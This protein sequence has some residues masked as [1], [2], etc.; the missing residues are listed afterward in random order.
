MRTDQQELLI[1]SIRA[2]TVYYKKLKIVPATI[3]Q[4]L[5][6][7]KIYTNIYD[8]CL[9]SGIMTEENLEMW[10]ISNNLLPKNFAQKKKDF[11]NAIDNT[12]ISLYKNRSSK[13]SIGKI[14]Y[15]LQEL[16]SDLIR[17]VEP[18][19]QYSQNTCEFI[20]NLEKRM[21]LLKETTFYNKKLYKGSN[22]NRVFEAWQDSLISEKNIRLLARSD[23][24][25]QLWNTKKTNTVSLFNY[26]DKNVELTINQRNL[27]TWSMIYDNVYESIESPEESVISDDDMLDG[28]F[29]SQ[30]EKREKEQTQNSIE[31]KIK[32][33]KVSN[34]GHV[35]VV[36]DSEEERQQINMASSH[37]LPEQFIHSQHGVVVNNEQLQT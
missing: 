8:E 21:F 17:L 36:A 10:M 32:T 1:Q 19:I 16:R 29:L 25:R 13:K 27:L 12:K 15:T 11:N 30:K 22:F 24:W 28:W 7:C 33:P 23:F 35:F 9:R 5:E 4:N 6:A 18:K 3:D 14:K 37:V 31:S 2:G 20:A 26:Y 34:S